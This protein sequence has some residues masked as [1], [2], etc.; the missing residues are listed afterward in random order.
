MKHRQDEIDALL[1]LPPATFHILVA[2]ADR[3]LPAI[4][5]L[6]I[7]GGFP[8]ACMDAL[9]ANVALREALRA[10]I[11]RGLPTYAE[12]AG[13]MYLARSIHWQ[14]RSA[15]MV[16]VIPGDAVMHARPV[17]RGYVRLEET[18]H[19]PWAAA[20][21]AATVQ[22]HEFHHS[23]LENLDPGVSFAYRVQRGHGVDGEHD[24]I[25]IHNLL[26]SYA[27]LR[28]GAG[29][30]WVPRFVAFVREARRRNADA[31]RVAAAAAAA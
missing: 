29:S 11:E 13:L 8:E 5:G 4:D 17:G 3:E 7:G 31:T 24:G 28:S 21:G 6:V 10:A 2:L 9:E 20:S 19:M 15:R 16:G 1:P 18:A 25:V 22:G 27:H 26:A 14:G 12:C 30:D 23:S